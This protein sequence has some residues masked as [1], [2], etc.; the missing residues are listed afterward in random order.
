MINLT[1]SVNQT[2]TLTLN[3]TDF[4]GNVGRIKSINWTTIS[5]NSTIIPSDNGMTAVITAAANPGV[6]VFKIGANTN[7][8]F[9]HCDTSS[10]ASS[11]DYPPVSTPS[12]IFNEVSVNVVQDRIDSTQGHT[13]TNL[14][15]SAGSPRDQV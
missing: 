11:F 8:K 14:G 13:T 10:L 15:V 7:M 3:P 2:I 4:A 6:T 5:G 1:L 12:I 9:K